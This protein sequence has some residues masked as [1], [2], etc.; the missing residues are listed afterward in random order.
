MSMKR[1]LTNHEHHHIVELKDSK[2][3]AEHADL[4]KQYAKDVD[5]KT[6]KKLMIKSQYKA[7]NEGYYV[8]HADSYDRTDQTYDADL[9][10]DQWLYG[11]ADQFLQNFD[12]IR[13]AA[14]Q[15]FHTEMTVRYFIDYFIA[16]LHTQFVNENHQ[17]RG[18]L[19][20]VNSYEKET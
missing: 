15:H 12:Q 6:L 17:N 18:K 14:R 5:Q 19:I 9:P 2:L 1:I 20:W 4:L 13:Q 10:Y 3:P 11:Y 16:M 8:A 7:V